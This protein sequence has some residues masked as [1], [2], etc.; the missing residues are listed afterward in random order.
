MKFWRKLFSNRVEQPL[1][2]SS[3]LSNQRTLPNLPS[4][5][6]RRIIAFTVRL[7]GSASIELDD[8]FSPPYQN[9]EYPEV[10]P[11]IFEDRKALRLVCSS[12]RSV[13]A[14]ISAEYLIIYSAKELKAL[15]KL[16][17]SQ[18]RH[19][20]NGKHLGEWTARIDFRI[21]GPYSVSHVIRP[22]LCRSLTRSS[23]SGG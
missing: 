14:E 22:A 3:I 2:T 8:P 20:T 23:P 9:E 11:G 13:V 4:E 10:E 17:E 16:F 7:A 6:W 21:L 15:V 5:I 1:A 12:W 19:K 18:D